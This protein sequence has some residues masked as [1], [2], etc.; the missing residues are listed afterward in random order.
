MIP[1][2]K[3]EIVCPAGT[4]AAFKVAVNAGADTIYCG[5]NNE[6]NARKQLVMQINIM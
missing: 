6:T 4:P 1:K 3:L 2:N 5:F